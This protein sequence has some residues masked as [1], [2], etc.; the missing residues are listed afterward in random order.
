LPFRPSQTVR[1]TLATSPAASPQGDDIR[2]LRHA[3]RPD[4]VLYELF[5]TPC[6]AR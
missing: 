4:M 1:A 3:L 6:S 2:T 5:T